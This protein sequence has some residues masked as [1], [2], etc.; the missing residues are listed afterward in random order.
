MIDESFFS[1]E[2]ADDDIEDDTDEITDP[3]DE[4]TINNIHDID[5]SNCDDDEIEEE[6]E[7]NQ[8]QIDSDMNLTM[9]L[10]RTIIHD[11][12]DAFEVEMEID[13]E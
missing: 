7:P 10:S 2:A 3:T 12:P 13:D 9:L 11:F 4:I 6:G 8:L 5:Q 1:W